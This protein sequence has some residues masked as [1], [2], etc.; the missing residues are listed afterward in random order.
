[1]FA[2]LLELSSDRLL[3]EFVF[4]LFELLELLFVACEEEEEED[5]VDVGKADS[6]TVVGV[7]NDGMGVGLWCLGTLTLLLLFVDV[8]SGGA[9]CC[10]NPRG[11]LVG[12]A[13]VVGS[14]VK[15]GPIWL[16]VAG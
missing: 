9:G 4:E 1:M 2:R 10:I 7:L 3:F 5:G 14:L 8:K 12:T 6:G 15:S 13:F 11:W 16:C